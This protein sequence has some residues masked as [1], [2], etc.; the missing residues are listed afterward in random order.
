MVK[1]SV[2]KLKI[3]K[4]GDIL[5]IAIFIALVVL[6]IVFSTG[7]K[8]SN[9]AIVYVDGKVYQYIDLSKDGNY[10][11]LDGDMTLQVKNGSLKVAHSNC[12]EQTCVHSSSI[13]NEGG[14]I[15]CLPNKVII[16]VTSKEVD[17]IT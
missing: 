16:K 8:T 9:E 4:K 2:E 17:V 11:I 13:S 10:D 14:M 3:F 6:T 5:L 12:P 15:I 7:S 1:K